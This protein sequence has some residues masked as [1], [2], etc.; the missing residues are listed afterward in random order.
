MKN[1]ITDDLPLCKEM[2]K[3]L[4]N[5]YEIDTFWNDYESTSISL[6]KHYGLKNFRG[7]RSIWGGGPD[8]KKSLIP[9][10]RFLNRIIT[11]M[12]RKLDKYFS[13]DWLR[14][15]FFDI[16][17]YAVVDDSK[18]IRESY[19]NFILEMIN[20]FPDADRLLNLKDDLL[21]NPNDVLIL[22]KNKYSLQ[23]I[24]YFYR[25]LVMNQYADFKKSNLFLEIGGGYGGFSEVLKKTYPNVKIIYIEIPPQLYVAERYLKGVFPG[26]VAGYRDTK[27]MKL[28]N[29]DSFNDY[30]IL[31]IPPWDI[32]KIEDK[33]IDNFSNQASFQEM[34]QDTVRDYC[35]QLGR[36]V[37]DKVVLYEMREGN[38]GV[39][40]PVKRDDYLSYMKSA[41]FNLL[42]EQVSIYGGHLRGDSSEPMCHQDFYIYQKI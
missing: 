15:P 38:G 30:D 41:G 33:L 2:M 25:L 11:S 31:I 13:I 20:F 10:G 17:N 12:L 18:G 42:N 3:D 27:K 7:Q 32:D 28:I 40:N 39:Q 5:Q 22:R 9:K 16:F 4:S 37:T 23:L 8:T 1:K 14:L 34:S 24:Q 36:I 35:Q 6:I 21:G 19:G 26:R 29:N